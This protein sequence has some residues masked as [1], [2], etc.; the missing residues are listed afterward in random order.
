[1]APTMGLNFHPAVVNKNKSTLEAEFDRKVKK[2]LFTVICEFIV[3]KGR[4]VP[5]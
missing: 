3:K 4:V 2:H 5:D 1:M